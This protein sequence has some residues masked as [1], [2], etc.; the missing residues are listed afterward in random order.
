M[1]ERLKSL[2]NR[3]CSI[4][5]RNGALAVNHPSDSKY[6]ANWHLKFSTVL[7]GDI[8]RLLRLN[9]YRY[10]G[11]KAGRFNEGKYPGVRVRFIDIGSSEEVYAMFNARLTRS[12]N[13]GNKRSGEPLP[14]NRFSM[15]KGYGLYKLW[16][17]L[18]LPQPRRPSELYKMMGKLSQIMITADADPNGKLKNQSIRLANVSTHEI[19]ANFSDKPV[20]SLGQGSG[21]VLASASGNNGWQEQVATDSG[22]Q[23][24]AT[25]SSIGS[26]LNLKCVSKPVR[27]GATTK[28]K[29][30]CDYNHELSNQVM[31]DKGPVNPTHKKT[32]QEQTNDE[33]F[34][35]YD[36]AENLKFRA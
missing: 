12:R 3:G 27:V 31:T 5:I 34:A 29:T 16:L 18:G 19:T 8:A 14:G 17:K 25:T 15:N 26:E 35:D 22:K 32:P 6:D 7:V 4:E 23:S 24:P 33:W 2:L 20:A 1:S 10:E 30:T 13:V 28:E 36:K 11:Y 9:I 21:K